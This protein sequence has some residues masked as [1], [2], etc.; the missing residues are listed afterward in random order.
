M[1]HVPRREA[2]ND[3]DGTLRDVRSIGAHCQIA[4]RGGC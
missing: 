4:D 1:R 2:S 3:Y